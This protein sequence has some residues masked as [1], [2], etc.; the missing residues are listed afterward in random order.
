MEIQVYE[1]ETKQ[2]RL[3]VV[4]VVAFNTVTDDGVEQSSVNSLARYAKQLLVTQGKASEEEAA[5]Y[6]YEA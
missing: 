2:K 1:D 3:H 4:N 6:H 5:R